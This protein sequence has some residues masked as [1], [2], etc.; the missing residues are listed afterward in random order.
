MTTPVQAQPL[1]AA[2]DSN[3]SRSPRDRIVA[4]TRPGDQPDLSP[5]QRAPVPAQAAG[6]VP[7]LTSAPLTLTGGLPFDRMESPLR[8]PSDV[9]V[10]PLELK[11]ADLPSARG[12]AL[13]ARMDLP[14]HVA[15]QV[16]DVAR[17][18]PDR[19]VELTLNPEELGRLR[20]T[21]T[22]DGGSMAVA[23]TAERPETMDL[24][25]RHID[26]LAQEL[27]E[28]GYEDVRFD[29]AQGGDARGDGSSSGTDTPS[30]ADMDGASA[31]H[32]TD[33]PNA[34]ARLSLG[35][36]GGIDIRL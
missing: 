36:G 25:R 11:G 1:Q 2:V 33:P 5:A 27:R 31:Q 16:A 30:F 3:L 24:L 32:L 19:P 17:M 10:T 15:Q 6:A 34:P 14:R 26:A 7:A 21:F 8:D 20:M 18:M 23:V 28:I 4:E 22:V 9:E 12:D 13:T 29:F 35:H